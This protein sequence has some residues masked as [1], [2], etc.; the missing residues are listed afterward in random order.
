MIVRDGL[1]RMLTEQEDVFYY[2][3][4]MNENYPHPPLP[5]GAEEGI[6]RGHVPPARGAG[7]RRAARP[8]P[9]LG[10]DPARGRWRRP[11]CSRRTSTSPPTCG[12]RRAS[13]SCGATGW[14]S[15]AGTC[16]TRPRSSAAPG[17]TRVPRRR[18]T[19]PIVAAT[20]YMRTF[21]DQI[22][23]W[24][25]GRYVVLGTDGFG[26]SDYRVKLRQ[27]LRGRP[28]PRRRRRAQGARRRRRRSSRRSSQPAIERYEIDT[29]PRPAVE[30]VS[31]D[32]RRRDAPRPL[33]RAPRPRA[34]VRDAEPVGRRLGAPA[35]LARVRGAR[36]DERGLRLGAR[37]A[38]PAGDA[39]RA[40]RP[41][42]GARRRDRPAAQRRQRALLPRR[43]RRR[44]RDGAPARRGGRRRLLDRG[45]RPRRRADRGRRLAAER[46]AEAAEAAHA[47][48]PPL[49]L[50]GRAENHLHGVDDLDDTIA[51]LV[52][53]RDAGADCVYAPWLATAEQ[54]AARRRGGRRAR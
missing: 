26:R 50:T 14:R 39:R 31:A 20:D 16:C 13:P 21:A 30:A 42:R 3:T 23:P 24:V 17:S 49:V 27:L 25:P 9:R 33:P 40:R 43:P 41:R 29:E 45:L 4:V 51:R 37:Q 35:R 44:R 52:A 48:D 38:R 7:G 15:S 8:A 2:L 1:R 54:I 28:L 34:A 6:L 5:E 12:A 11:S 53:Y 22:R 18:A 47:F 46:V 19:G 32:D 36:D 10:R